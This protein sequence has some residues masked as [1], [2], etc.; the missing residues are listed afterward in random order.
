MMH[1]TSPVRQHIQMIKISNSH[2]LPLPRWGADYLGEKI[3]IKG[4]G[5]N[6]IISRAIKPAASN[7]ITIV[8]GK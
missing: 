1:F 8:P 6:R 5:G 7:G 2:P 4:Y 3:T